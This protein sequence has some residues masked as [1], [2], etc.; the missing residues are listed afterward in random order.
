M[1]KMELIELGFFTLIS[2]V[3]RETNW[4]KANDNEL[5]EVDGELNFAKKYPNFNRLKHGSARTEIV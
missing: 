2:K 1:T 4:I 3:Y 5:V